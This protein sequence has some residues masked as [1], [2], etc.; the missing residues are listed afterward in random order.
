M[1]ASQISV[2]EENSLKLRVYGE[3]ASIEWSQLEPNSLSMKFADKPSQLIR[4]GVGKMSNLAEENLR[5]PAGHPEGYLEAFA[6]IYTQFSYQIRR[7]IYPESNTLNNNHLNDEAVND[8]PGINEAI[9]G[10]AFIEN[11]VAASKS[12]LKWHVFQLNP[13]EIKPRQNIKSKPAT[14]TTAQEKD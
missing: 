9:R 4:A 5:T 3:N 7:L 1:L 13:N 2:G 10:M 14:L 6:N 12:E 8:V 11:V